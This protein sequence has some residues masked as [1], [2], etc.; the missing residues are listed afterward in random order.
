MM[1]ETKPFNLE[2][3]KAGAPYAC[4]SGSTAVIL[5]W[6]AVNE[7]FP[8]IG[9][10]TE[11]NSDYIESWGADGIADF[12]SAQGRD[13]VMTPL[14]HIDGKPVFVGDKVV[15]QHGVECSVV[16]HDRG[17]SDCRWPAPAKQYPVTKIS[18]F[19]L[20]VEY[21]KALGGVDE[22]HAA[23]ANAALR[24]AIDNGQVVTIDD[25]RAVCSLHDKAF[26]DRAARD[27]AIAETVQQKA[28]DAVRNATQ[29]FEC[30]N[31]NSLNL[32]AIIASV[33]DQ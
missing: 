8:L 31:I 15:N 4:I 32:A 16:A 24:H 21:V 5:K 1:K 30:M 22:G 17:F 27:M 9:Y 10:V 20:H 33:K 14:G 7:K 23:V 19:D 6:D 12:A 26:N 3:A 25:Y 28:F 13:L 2:H 18:A 11:Y 29:G